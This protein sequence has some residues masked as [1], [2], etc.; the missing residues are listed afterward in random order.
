MKILFFTCTLLFVFPI[1]DLTCES[2]EDLRQAFRI[3]NHTLT[4]RSGRKFSQYPYESKLH[5]DLSHSLK[6]LEMAHQIYAAY[7]AH[8][9]PI[10]TKIT[11][12]NTS[13]NIYNT[14]SKALVEVCHYFGSHYFSPLI[15]LKT[16]LEYH[17]LKE[18]SD[19]YH[20]EIEV[21]VKE[22]S[23][24]LIPF[25]H[26]GEKDLFTVVIITTSSSGGNQS[27]ALSIADWLQTQPNIQTIVIDAEEI[28][29]ELDPLMI[30][31]D[32]YTYDGV[33]AHILQKNNDLSVVQARKTLI[34]EIENYIPNNTL[35]LLKKKV[36]SYCPNL[37]ISTRAYTCDDIS[38]SVLGVPFCLCHTD[39]EL[40][41]SLCSFYRSI[42]STTIHFWIPTLKP[43][44]FR[45]LFEHMDRLSF[46]NEHD[47]EETL[48]EK[49]DELIVTSHGA[50]KHFELIGYPCMHFYNIEDKEFLKK[51][52]EIASNEIAVFIVM[53]KHCTSSMQDVFNQLKE[54]QTD[55]PLKYL[56]VCGKN[57]S[58]KSELERTAS[59]AMRIYGHLSPSEMN[60]IMNLSTLGISKAGGATTVEALSTNTPL[61]IFDSYPWEEANGAY[62]IEKGLGKFANPHIP[63]I[64]QIEDM[65]K[66]FKTHSS[67][68]EEWKE[69][70]SQ[71][72]RSFIAQPAH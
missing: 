49:L 71:K 48:F 14:F 63:L 46:F 19:K 59:S 1:F 16:A 28:A 50:K 53:G 38:L 40:Y 34:R 8:I 54:A 7:K 12:E 32:I 70:L 47:N 42:P 44:L 43:S 4:T 2:I 39:Y 18:W 72:I 55:L 66:N 58:L 64:V 30:A 51:K 11:D 65:I 10:I 60:E 56:F 20:L 36:I 27:V 57:A 68:E 5:F 61:L 6:D 3:E 35:S 33:Y 22:A 26:V 24:P 23:A 69:N 21:F 37:I 62:L 41:S 52:W 17:G 25:H 15:P 9:L 31:T 29:R 13:L 67:H 45:P